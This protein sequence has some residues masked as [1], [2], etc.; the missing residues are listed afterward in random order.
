METVCNKC[1]ACQ[2]KPVKPMTKN[3]NEIVKKCSCCGAQ[4]DP[5]TNEPLTSS[6]LE[7]SFEKKIQKKIQ[8]L[9]D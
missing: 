2:G 1:L 9:N 8:K 5:M 6:K 3:L 7:E 4:V